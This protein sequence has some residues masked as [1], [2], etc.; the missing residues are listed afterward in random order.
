MRG[1]RF[2]AAINLANAYSALGSPEKAFE[3]DRW[4]QRARET[5]R[6]SFTTELR[7]DIVA[8]TGPEDALCYQQGAPFGHIYDGL[9]RY[10]RKREQA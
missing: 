6:D 1:F 5:D 9:E 2:G 4:A 8:S 7:E 10:W 3:L